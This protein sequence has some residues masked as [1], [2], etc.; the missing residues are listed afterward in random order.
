MKKSQLEL[1]KDKFDEEDKIHEKENFN[2][3][4]NFGIGDSKP[5]LYW[6]KLYRKRRKNNFTRDG[7]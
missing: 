3:N 5:P 1:L 4:W 2:I 6:S 7:R